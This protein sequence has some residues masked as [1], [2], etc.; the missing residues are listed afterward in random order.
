MSIS[1]TTNFL[2]PLPDTGSSN[3]GAIINGMSETIDIELFK[4]Q[5]PMVNRSGEVLV[6]LINGTVML[7]KYSSTG[8]S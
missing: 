6:S 3:W 7:K 2:F 5:N 4:A 8:G 1:F